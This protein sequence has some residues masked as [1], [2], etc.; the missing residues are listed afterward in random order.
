MTPEQKFIC[1]ILNDPQPL[2]DIFKFLSPDD[3]E[4]ADYGWIY[5]AF[6]KSYSGM[7]MDTA[8]WLKK[9]YE[10]LAEDADV[11]KTELRVMLRGLCDDVLEGVNAET[12][13]RVIRKASLQRKLHAAAEDYAR[14]QVM[15][16]TV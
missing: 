8:A 6:L 14:F 12:L 2:P 7:A 11:N 1:T 5:Y 4:D 13:A 15:R 3:F 9:M 16:V 10:V